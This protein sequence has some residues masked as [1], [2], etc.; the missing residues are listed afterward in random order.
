MVGKLSFVYC[1][2]KYIKIK[3]ETIATI[4]LPWLFF[5]LLKYWSNGLSMTLP[6][7]YRITRVSLRRKIF[8]FQNL[9][10]PNSE[11]FFSCQGRCIHVLLELPAPRAYFVMLDINVITF[12]DTKILKLLLCFKHIYSIKNN[13]QTFQ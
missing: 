4:K 7:L 13:A 3:K 12:W 10:L 9:N 2:L 5:S 8:Y 6:V 1:F 11:T